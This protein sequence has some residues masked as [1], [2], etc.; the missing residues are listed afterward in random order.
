LLDDCGNTVFE[1][2]ALS[3]V[4]RFK[5]LGGVYQGMIVTR[6]LEWIQRYKDLYLRVSDISLAAEP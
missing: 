3:L 4:V 2:C 5:H 1:W 6:T